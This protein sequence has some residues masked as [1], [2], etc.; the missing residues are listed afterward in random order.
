FSF[1][2]PKFCPTVAWNP[3]GITFA[4]QTTIGEKPRAIFIN[5]NNTIYVYANRQILVSHEG[6]INP[7]KIIPINSSTSHSILV[8]TNGDIY[9]DNDEVVLK[10]I[11]NK[12]TF[13]TAM[14]GI[15]QCYGLFVDINDTLHCSM[16]NLHQVVKRWMSDS[17]LTPTIVAGTNRSGSAPNELNTPHGIFIDVNV[18]LYVADCRNDR[19][20]LFQLGQS[21]G[22]T[23]AGNGSPNPTISLSCPTGIVLD[24][25]KYLFILDSWNRRI[26]GSGPNGFRCLVGCHGRGSQS[27]Q[28]LFPLS[29]SF[30]RSGNM[31][32]TDM[33]N[34]RIQKYLLKK[35]C[36]MFQ[37][38]DVKIWLKGKFGSER[39]Q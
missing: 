22:I 12:N 15:S 38:G 3:F 4:N 24:A 28:L 37:G 23:V 14:K 18:D 17:V 30:D 16:R 34:D 10:W 2:Q 33:N 5:T 35:S 31:F 36:V 32:V 13:D 1:N 39:V 9:I 20:Q 6:H 8:T 26:V 25:Q 21:I 7:T 19:V 29:L 27:H 11:S